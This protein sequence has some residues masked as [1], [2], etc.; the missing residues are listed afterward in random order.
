V[1]GDDALTR[2]DHSLQLDRDLLVCLEP[3]FR[4]PNHSLVAA[5]GL[6]NVVGQDRVLVDDRRIEERH[7]ALVAGVPPLQQRSKSVDV[8][9]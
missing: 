6:A 3:A 2:V 1:D 4:R 8:L 5:V 7:I 9:L